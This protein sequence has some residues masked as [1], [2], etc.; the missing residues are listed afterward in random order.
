MHNLK[1]ISITLIFSLFTL[2]LHATLLALK[3]VR[4]W[5][6][7]AMDDVNIAVNDLLSKSAG[8]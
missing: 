4:N 1:L 3:A 7:T 6:L 2:F 5:A 8:N